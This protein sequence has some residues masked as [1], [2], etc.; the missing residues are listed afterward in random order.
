ARAPRLPEAALVLRAADPR[1]GGHRLVSARWQRNERR[2]LVDGVRPSRGSVPERDG[3]PRARPARPTHPR[4]LVLGA[5]DRPPWP[6]AVDPPQTVGH[7][8]GGR[9]GHEREHGARA[10]ARAEVA[11]RSGS[12]PR[13]APQ[14][15]GMSVSFSAQRARRPAPPSALLPSVLRGVPSLPLARRIASSSTPASASRTPSASCPT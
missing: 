15:G 10:E 9:G 14:A 1:H 5:A 6:P 13:V 8:L 12:Q 7:P 11:D 2:G 3:P 4:R